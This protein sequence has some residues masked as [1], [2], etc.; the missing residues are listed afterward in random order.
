MGF[1]PKKNCFVLGLNRIVIVYFAAKRIPWTTPSLTKNSHR[2][3]GKVYLGG[4]INSKNNSNLL[5]PL[6]ESLFGL[7]QNLLNNSDLQQNK[8]KLCY[9]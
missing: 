5:P 8:T 3:L 1:S 9:L 7:F 2:H 6:K 4:L